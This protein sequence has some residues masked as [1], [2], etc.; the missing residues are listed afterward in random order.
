MF[1]ALIEFAQIAMKHQKV[2]LKTKLIIIIL[3]TIRR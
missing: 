3:F 2:E 1:M